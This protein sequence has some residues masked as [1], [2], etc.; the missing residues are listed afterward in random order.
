MLT[1]GEVIDAGSPVLVR[2]VGDTSDTPCPLANTDVVGVVGTNDKVLLA[3]VGGTWVI[4]C[5]LEAT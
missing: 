3:L 4:T 5:I 1:W 2:I